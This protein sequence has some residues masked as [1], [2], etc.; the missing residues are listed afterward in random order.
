MCQMVVAKSVQ[1]YF[2]DEHG[3]PDTLLAQFV[4]PDTGYCQPSPHW[5]LTLSKQLAW[6]PTYL[7]CF[8]SMIPNDNSDRSLKL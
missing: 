7:Q 8:R 4:D 1:P 2:E 3:Q 6:V 5:K